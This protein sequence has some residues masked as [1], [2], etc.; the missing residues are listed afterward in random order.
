MTPGE[1]GANAADLS[2]TW[3]TDGVDDVGRELL[4]M[5]PLLAGIAGPRV[6]LEIAAMPCGCPIHLSKE[7]L[8]RVML[9]LVRNARDAMP[10]GGRLRITAQYGEGPSFL[11]PGLIPDGRPRT[12][13]IAVED[14]GPGIPQDILEET[15]LPGFTTRPAT[16]GWPQESHRGL[17]LSIVRSLVGRR[18]GRHAPLR[19]PA[20]ERASNSSCRL[21][22]ACMKSRTP[23]NWWLTRR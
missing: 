21:L 20:R 2:G 5:R 16:A 17:G 7:D 8:T 11:E 10:E 3:A 6:E 13:T 1:T 9:N 23:P 4:E 19:G 12:V 18:A 14:S 22:R 15:F